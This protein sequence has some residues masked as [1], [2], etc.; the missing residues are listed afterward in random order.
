MFAILYHDQSYA[1]KSSFLERFTQ[2]TSNHLSRLDCPS[3]SAE[4][5][6]GVRFAVYQGVSTETL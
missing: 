4:T 5:L 2:Q 3:V 1:S 6:T